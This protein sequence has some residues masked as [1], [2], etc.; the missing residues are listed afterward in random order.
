MRCFRFASS[1]FLLLF[2]LG[3]IHTG[4]VGNSFVSEKFGFKTKIPKEPFVLINARGT[5]LTLIDEKSGTSIT[6]TVTDEKYNKGDEEIGLLYLARELFIYIEDK[7]YLV[8]ENFE[9]GGVP[10]WYMEL[11]GK[12]EG[13]SLMF[14][15]YVVRKNGRICDIVMWS[16]P[17]NFQRAKETLSDMVEN[18]EFL[19]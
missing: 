17:D 8:S 7:D 19:P 9:L 14:S 11:S 4:V 5:A 15:A 16:P 10:A 18:F 3:C 1:L 12:V 2:I 13:V 6:V